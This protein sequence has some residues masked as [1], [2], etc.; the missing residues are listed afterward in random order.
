[1]SE[2]GVDLQCITGILRSA[3]H[4]LPNARDKV[5]KVVNSL[6]E[7]LLNDIINNEINP[8]DL[9]RLCEVE[10]PLIKAFAL[11]KP[12]RVTNKE[13]AQ[14]MALALLDAGKYDEAAALVE[15]AM[16]LAPNADDLDYLRALLS[17]IHAGSLIP[18]AENLHINN[19]H[20]EEE[21]LITRAARDYI[22]AA[23]IYE[24][25][26][27]HE[28]AELARFNALDL[29]AKHYFIHGNLDDALK[30]Y[31]RCMA[32]IKDEEITK[33]CK[34]MM[35]L[36]YAVMSGSP[37]KHVVAGDE[38][39]NNNM[40]QYALLA[41]GSA[42]QLNDDPYIYTKY[43]AALINYID[44]KIRDEY[45]SFMN[46]LNDIRI[47][48]IK[49]VADHMGVSYDALLKYLEA[50]AALE[51]GREPSALIRYLANDEEMISIVKKKLSEWL[52]Q[53]NNET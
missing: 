49:S 21:E 19:N 40:P 14:C 50:K 27:E 10:P 37:E 44:D 41:Y 35:M 4:E 8:E 28:H 3:I 34:S 33:I 52:S 30:Q 9:K 25:I 23:N 12:Y 18:K 32:V 31:T 6:P 15:R 20:G 13:V 2:C 48:G 51:Y 43:I 22:N 24:A 47:T 45:G 53:E 5:A 38:L 1:M 46:L 36:I 7:N 42:Y 17:I 29:L 11:V 16:E 26:N 39:M